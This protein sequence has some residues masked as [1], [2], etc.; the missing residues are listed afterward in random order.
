MLREVNSRC[1][2]F[3]LACEALRLAASLK[4]VQ[5]YT[6][7]HRRQ[8]ESEKIDCRRRPQTNCSCSYRLQTV[9]IQPQTTTL[10]IV[11]PL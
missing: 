1:E 8:E 4:T 3:Q 6:V 2:C 11:L 7:Y 10:P 5:N 9:L